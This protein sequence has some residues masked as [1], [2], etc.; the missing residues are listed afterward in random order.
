MAR[1]ALTKTVH[2]IQSFTAQGWED[3]TQEDTWS[4]AR[5]RLKEYRENSP[6]AVRYITRRVCVECG[7]PKKAHAGSWCNASQDQ[8]TTPAEVQADKHADDQYT[9]EERTLRIYRIIR[10]RLHGR[11]R[12]TRNGLTL[13]EVQRHC[14]DPKTHGNGWFDGYDLMK[15][16]SRKK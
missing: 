13:Q 12:T 3:E 5:E 14:S 7:E 15:G 11:P 10:F 8:E 6:M 9:D 16:V 4:E 2:V 1:Q